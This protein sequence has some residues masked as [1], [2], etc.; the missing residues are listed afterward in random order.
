MSWP[1]KVLWVVVLAACLG[2]WQRLPRRWMEAAA[3]VLIAGYAAATA[4]FL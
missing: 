2:L 3:A 1:Q 4:L